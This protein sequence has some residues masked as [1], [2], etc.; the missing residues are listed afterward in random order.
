MRPVMTITIH[1]GYTEGS[2]SRELSLPGGPEVGTSTPR[3]RK[4]AVLQGYFHT[5]S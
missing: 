5:R 2:L 3:K 4:V 1:I